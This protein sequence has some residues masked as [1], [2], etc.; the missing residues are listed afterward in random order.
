MF[1]FK[2]S[3]CCQGRIRNHHYQR[4]ASLHLLKY[5]LFTYYVDE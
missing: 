3:F 5:D 2:A 4:R 1:I